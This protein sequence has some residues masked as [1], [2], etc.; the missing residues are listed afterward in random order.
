MCP[1]S[2]HRLSK[3]A[4]H[5]LPARGH[6]A[7]DQGIA[8]RALGPLQGLVKLPFWGLQGTDTGRIVDHGPWLW[9]K[10]CRWLSQLSLQNFPTHVQPQF[11]IYFFNA[12][13]KHQ[14]VHGLELRTF[15]IFPSWCI[16]VYLSTSQP[17]QQVV[18]LLQISRAWLQGAPAQQFLT[19]VLQGDGI[20]IR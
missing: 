11:Q 1:T 9:R 10:T 15:H 6:H 5:A 19:R 8:D 2:P 4:S 13:K 7:A 3:Y 18:G 17:H 20:A 14:D 16:W 12:P